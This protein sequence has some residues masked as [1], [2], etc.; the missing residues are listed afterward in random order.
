MPTRTELI[1]WLDN[2]HGYSEE[3]VDAL[4]ARWPHI[5]GLSTEIT[6][7]GRLSRTEVLRMAA[8]EHPDMPTSDGIYAVLWWLADAGYDVGPHIAGPE[9]VGSVE[10]LDALPVGSLILD[11]D[12]EVGRVTYGRGR[13]RWIEEDD[14][15]SFSFVRFPAQVLFRPDATNPEEGT[16]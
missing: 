4:L 5:A 7:P 8:S 14:I 1:E 13:I 2:Q 12:E 10:E 9:R 3:I 11:A 6:K 15:T 16:R